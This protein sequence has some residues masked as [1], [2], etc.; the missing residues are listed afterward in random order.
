MAA[1]LARQRRV[2]VRREGLTNGRYCYQHHGECI[3]C[4]T[5]LGET[6]GR[7]MRAYGLHEH[8]GNLCLT[9]EHELAR[10]NEGELRTL[11]RI[12]VRVR[13]WEAGNVLR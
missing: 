2:I 11:R 5:R 10:S 7:A 13:A 6:T 12:K 4:G 3:A 8:I 1:H 9:C